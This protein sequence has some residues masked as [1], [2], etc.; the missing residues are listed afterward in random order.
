MNYVARKVEQMIDQ[1][2]E[3]ISESEINS[4]FRRN[5]NG[6]RIEKEEL[7]H[8]IPQK[9]FEQ[10]SELNKLDEWTYEIQMNY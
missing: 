10:F 5:I 7:D 6:Y 2:I 8:I 1:L 3:N 9:G 4:F